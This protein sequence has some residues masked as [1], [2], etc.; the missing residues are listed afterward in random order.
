MCASQA[1]SAQNSNAYKW[2]FSIDRG[3]TFTDVIGRRSDG[4]LVV[5]KLL[6]VNDAHYGD[7]ALEGIRVILGGEFDPLQISQVRMGTT[8]ATNAL[9]ERK[10]ERT[11]LVVN[12]GFGDALRI[13]YQNRPDI[14]AR[15]IVLPEPIY[16]DVIE[17]PGRISAHGEV[18]Q[19][20]DER[21]AAER[22]SMARISGMTSCA[23]VFMHNYRYPE[24]EELCARIASQVG[25][26]HVTTSNATSPL[27]K[28]VYRGNTTV[29]D[30]YL[31]P[32][33]HS[34]LDRFAKPFQPSKK[35]YFMQ[36]N[37]G[38]VDK[39][40]F[41]GKDSLLSGPAGG[42]V[43]AVKT[44]L[45]LGF[46]KVI[47]FDMGGTSTDVSHFD[48][49]MERQD[50][51]TIGGIRLR[52]PMIAVNTIAAGGGSILA[53]DGH[54]FRVG[55][56]S[57]GACP[58]PASY[59]KGGPLALTD[60]NVLLGRIQPDHFP[61]VFGADANQPLDRQAVIDKFE[62]LRKRVSA[63]HNYEN[64]TSIAWGFIE[65]AVEKMA[66][67]IRKVTIE[68]GFDIG[69]YVL[70]SFG[71]AGGQ[72]ACLIAE[73]LGLE[74]VVIH[75]LAGVL[76]A[77]GIALADIKVVVH[78]SVQKPLSTDIILELEKS[79]AHL[80]DDAHE[81]LLAQGAAN[82]NI[83]LER[84]V[85]IR[86]NGSDTSL[87]IAFDT[88][89]A[90]AANFHDSHHRRYGFR[91][92]EKELIAESVTIE[93]TASKDD[94]SL[95]AESSLAAGIDSVNR[96]QVNS[97]TASD[98]TTEN[99]DS[100]QAT[101]NRKI[102]S[103]QANKLASLPAT[104]VATARMY[105]GDRWHDAQLHRRDN[106]QPGQRIEGPAIIL[107][108]TSTNIVEPGWFA[109]IAPDHSL[110]IRFSG[111][112]EK[113]SVTEATSTH[114]DPVTLELF[115]NKFMA[116]AEEMGVTLCHTSHSVNI[117]ERLDF[118]CALFDPE[119]R[120]I[121]NAPH[122]P[123]HLGSMGESVRSVVN[124]FSGKM[125]PG[126]V[127]LL[128]N[129]YRGGT[130]LPDI[131]VVT[132]V[133]DGSAKPERTAGCEDRSGK[134]IFY[135]A[136]RGHHADIGGITP[137][138]MPPA[139]KH[140]DEEGALIDPML[141]VREGEFQESEIRNVLLKGTFPT[142]NVEQNISD[143]KA[144]VA[145][146]NRGV[147]SVL[148]MIED[149]GLETVYAYMHFVRKNAEDCVRDAIGKLSDG[150]F[151]LKMD[152]GSTIKV[153]ISV[154][155]ETRTATVDFAGTSPQ[156]PN[157]LNA[158]C[159]ITIAAVLYVFRTLVTDNIPLND[160]CLAPL[161][162]LVPEGTMLN[163]QPPAAV[164]AGN[165]E[166]SQ[167]VVDALY[168]ALNTMAASQG[169]MNNFTFG[170]DKYQY[171]E[172]I[173]GGSGAGPSHE[174]TDAVHTHM[175]NSRLTDPEILEWRFPILLKEFSIRRGS[176]GAGKFRGGDGTV[177][178]LTFLEPMR[179]S[180]LSE[181]RIV[182]PFGLDGGA[183]GQTG[184][185]YVIRKSGAIEVF[186]ARDSTDMDAGDTFVIE[187]PGAG[188]WGRSEE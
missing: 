21:V 49:V 66:Q 75:P 58:G 118:S 108:D 135:T 163:P 5:H 59:R 69:N 143:L 50:E 155:H 136:S 110:I 165:V 7:A 186:T 51:N 134:P 154:D 184:K 149:Y 153:N 123:V 185:N 3:G 2:R 113:P 94:G 54:R 34:Y 188:A 101:E 88:I 172:T 55:P 102:D 31:S 8:V 173:C 1:E 144:Q 152:S 25:F 178:K 181:R 78:K 81:K 159:A 125:Q 77:F 177:R 131:T 170:N 126:D 92:P 103:V 41:K 169:T 100:M 37:G 73:E 26:A 79:F 83:K 33:L 148:K 6:S 62:Q 115:N 176:G 45:S 167:A 93:A 39:E 127:Y 166:T 27:I 106:L 158:P 17:L 11:V 38:L 90:M 138:S 114:A 157:N 179:A 47:S 132:P 30:A 111:M 36:S 151:E 28:F 70:N 175:T 174:G 9:L 43:G 141:L 4:K 89:A 180:I 63:V 164:V 95:G 14:F 146:N 68:R 29:A 183:P 71:G 96:A 56:D 52:V 67:A 130:H 142:R 98:S 23:I 160:G 86:Y 109:E 91:S 129:P 147:I 53:F 13:G 19:E 48:G 120:L 137:G 104:K 140:I 99:F 133:F 20:F 124:A 42:V 12:E 117:K 128:N 76:S 97:Q 107:D 182:S 161:N 74:T 122:M 15:H 85:M 32:I 40:H 162:I 18:L 156:Q 80:S 105:S 82:T 150:S 57:A 16:A 64:S 22:L 145:A 121:A 139:S 168:G 61:H 65:I 171:Y 35:I 119:G 10:G 24:H 72:F 46:D 84:L 187:T 112:N 87:P 60:A 116:I 44:C